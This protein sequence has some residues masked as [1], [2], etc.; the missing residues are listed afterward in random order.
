MAKL[1]KNLL[2]NI[3]LQSDRVKFNAQDGVAVRAEIG[4]AIP[5]LSACVERNLL[6]ANFGEALFAFWAFAHWDLHDAD[7]YTS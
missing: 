6:N 2:H 1:V 3:G 4:D 5:N 7:N